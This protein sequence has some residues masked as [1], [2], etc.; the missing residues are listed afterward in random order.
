MFPGVFFFTPTMESTTLEHLETTQAVDGFTEEKYHGK[1]KFVVSMDIGTLYTSVSFAHCYPGTRARVQ[2]V[3]HWPGTKGHQSGKIPTIVSYGDGAVKSC[4]AEAIQDLER[5]SK[6]VAHAFKLHL[7]PK[8][9]SLSKYRIPDLPDKVTVE[10][11]YADFMS[12]LMKHT[13]KFFERNTPDGSNIWTRGAGE[14][15]IILT[16]PSSWGLRE[17]EALKKAAIRAGLITKTNA[18]DFLKFVPQV[19]ASLHSILFNRTAAWLEESSPFAVMDIGGS[20][21]DACVYECKSTSTTE[22]REVCAA[23]CVMAGGMLLNQKVE[24]LVLKRLAKEQNDGV[25]S[26]NSL[27]KKFEQELKKDFDGSKAEHVLRYESPIKKRRGWKELV[28]Q[29]VLRRPKLRIHTRQLHLSNAEL[30]LAFSDIEKSIT[31]LC[32]RILGGFK[33]KY[34]LLVGGFGESPYLQNVLSHKLEEYGANLVVVENPLKKASAEGATTWYIQQLIKERSSKVVLP[35]DAQAYNGEERIVVSMDIGTVFSSVSFAY[36]APG[37]HPESYPVT[38]WPSQSRSSHGRKV[39]TA[40]SYSKGVLQACGDG[41]IADLGSGDKEVAQYFKLHLHP[42]SMNSAVD[43]IPPRLPTGVDIEQVYADMME[44]LMNST[45]RSCKTKIQTGG[46]VWSRVR[47][48]VVIILTT[49]NGWDIREQTILRN[50]AVKARLVTA[51]KSYDLVQFVTESE[52]SI[53]TTLS[54][55]A[56]MWLKKDALFAVANAGGSTVDTALYECKSV[57]PLELREASSSNCVQ[58]GGVYINQQLEQLISNKL[59]DSPFGTP[60][61]IRRMVDSFERDVKPRFDG[62]SSSYSL[63]FGEPQ[64]NDPKLGIN[65][66][67]LLLPVKDL[68]SVFRAVEKEIV[69]SCSDMVQGHDVKFVHLVGGLGSSPYLQQALSQRFSGNGITVLGMG[70]SEQ[71]E[72]HV[73]STKGVAV[74]LINQL[75]TARAAKATFGTCI[76]KVYSD[77]HHATRRHKAFIHHDGWKKVPDV[78]DKWIEKGDII[79]DTFAYEAGYHQ[80]LE[81]SISRREMAHHLGIMDLDIFSWEKPGIPTWCKDENGVIHTGMRLRCTLKADLSALAPS[82]R[83]KR[84]KHGGMY[85][86][87][88][89]QVCVFFGGTQLRAKLQWK[90]NGVLCEGPVGVI[91]GA[92]EVKRVH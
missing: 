11:A 13:R 14:P 3:T 28:K 2:M 41:A 71:E 5:D 12:Y 32:S 10:Q 44:Y 63:N 89:F 37:C 60:T 91:P 20:T 65:K 4:G 74:S 92:L 61:Y 15:V 38:D 23:K 64:D 35:V 26:T 73:A 27:M 1:E 36:F 83:P 9:S 53:H 90:H 43:F 55:H 85:Y 47:N 16:I 88:E 79:E 24:K 18:A 50:A 58:I 84:G 52:A 72:E 76:L 48:T 19:E 7:H 40:V 67:I 22:L 54:N 57:N 69:D 77:V 6:I 82:L 80:L 29:T 17:Q 21:V 59:K 62:T 46:E 86:Q 56:D 8:T 42:P 81:G 87:A 66:G 34:L 33:V 45:E 78:F 75:V 31:E 25:D 51:E 39:P 70:Q 30:R 49:P 68:V